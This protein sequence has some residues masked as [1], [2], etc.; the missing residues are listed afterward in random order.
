MVRVF[1]EP[2]RPADFQHRNPPDKGGSRADR[3]RHRRHR[4]GVHGG[5]RRAG[6]GVGIFGRPGFAQMDSGVVASDIQRGHALH[7]ACRR[8]GASDTLPQR[9]HGRRR[10]VLL[11]GGDVAFEPAALPHPRDGP[12]HTPDFAIRRD[13]RKR[14]HIGIHRR[15]LRLAGGVLRVRLDRRAVGCSLHVRHAQHADARPRLRRAGKIR[16]GEIRQNVLGDFEKA[17]LLLPRARVR[18]PML[19]KRRLQHVDAVVPA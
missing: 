3:L 8:N 15:A 11:S 1:S 6:S 13:N 9:R 10:G 7:G 18:L 12:L 4:D 16:K 14:L 17:D 19:R 2:G 5:L